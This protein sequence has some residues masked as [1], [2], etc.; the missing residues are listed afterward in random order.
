M[1]TAW[2]PLTAL[3]TLIT[4]GLWVTLTTYVSHGLDAH[5]SAGESEALGSL[6]VPWGLPRHGYP[7][8]VPALGTVSQLAAT[9]T[10]VLSPLPES[11]WVRREPR[12]L[13]P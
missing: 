10:K 9:G 3:A 13:S 6:A 12:G 4:A 7:G 1:P 5:L 11:A 2:V 8:S